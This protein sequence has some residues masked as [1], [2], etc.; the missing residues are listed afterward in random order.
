MRWTSFIAARALV[1]A[2]CAPCL[3]ACATGPGPVEPCPSTTVAA[4]AGTDASESTKAPIDISVVERVGDKW[5]VTYRFA[6]PVM[7]IGFERGQ[8]R[9]RYEHWNIAADDGATPVEWTEVEGR[10]AIV[11]SAPMHALTIRLVTDTSEKPSDYLVHA[12]FADGSRLFYTGHFAAR[13]LVCK[14]TAP[15]E[16]KQVALADTLA[17]GDIEWHF[18]T[19]AGRGIQILDRRE[20]AKLDWSPTSG[21]HGDGTYVYFGNIESIQTPFGQMVVDPGLP[22]WMRESANTNI[23]KLLAWFAEATQTEL[24]FKPVLFVSA[25]PDEE[26]GRYSKGGSL[27]GLIQLAAWGRGWKAETPETREAWVRFVAHELFHLWNG[28]MFD[29]RDNRADAWMSEGSSDY[30]SFAAARALGVIDDERQHRLLVQAANQCLLSVGSTPLAQARGRGNPEYSCGA[31]L[32]AFVDGIAREKKLDAGDVIGGV[33]ARA[34]SSDRRYGTSDV[35]SELRRIGG[36]AKSIDTIERIV[37]QGLVSAADEVVRA[38]LAKAGIASERVAP[39]QASLDG[40][41]FS[42]LVGRELAVCDCDG[43][44]SFTGSDRG[45]DFD[46]VPECTLLKGVRVTA[47]GKYAL[48][49]DGANAFDALVTRDD[50]VPLELKVEGRRDPLRLSCRSAYR[51]LPFT[52]LLK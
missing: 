16:A 21:E 42:S 11:A 32:W 5:E 17:P 39:S 6:K 38:Q 46:D 44:I 52:K 19:E 47:L 51:R 31:M 33:F 7:G 14:G 26:P 49:A 18:A 3:A 8:H 48:P 23:P 29:R 50:K 37:N 27:P 36:E 25:P 43:R 35:I 20:P 40:A 45:L 10:E 30:F 2:V 1:I 41:R 28:E 13:P 15:C 12:A 22:K 34:A 9:F 24:T 4:S